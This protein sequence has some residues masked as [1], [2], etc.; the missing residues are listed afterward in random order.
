VQLYYKKNGNKHATILQSPEKG[1]F[2][3]LLLINRENKK[4][5]F[6]ILFALAHRK[7]KTNTSAAFQLIATSLQA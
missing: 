4:V 7:P 3:C 6:H 2:P 5:N 1:D